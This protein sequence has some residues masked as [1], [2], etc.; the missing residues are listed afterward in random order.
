MKKYR[1]EIDGLR[2]LAIL[3]VILFHAGFKTFSGGFVGVDV[4]FVISGYLITSIILAEN[5]AGTFSLVTF[6]ERRARRILPALFLVMFVSLTFAWFQLLPEDMTKFSAS[7]VAVSIF[8]SNFLFW[9][10]SGYFEHANELSPLLHTW[11]LAVEEQYYVLFPLFLM[12]TWKLGK[13][14]ILTALALMALLG[15]GTAHWGSINKLTFTFYFLPTRGWEILVGAFIAFYYTNHKI[16]KHDYII[17]ELGSLFGFALIIYSIF[18][19]DSQTPFP[20]LYTLAPTIGAALIII[21]STDKTLVG[22][23][24][25]T[26]LML[27]IGL[28]SYSAYLWHQPL[29]AFA[30]QRSLSEPSLYLM[31]TLAVVSFV[32]AYL[33]WQY[34]ERPFRNKHR[35]S[36]KQVFAY[37]I[38]CSIFFIG[39][40]LAGFLNKGFTSRMPIPLRNISETEMPTIDN[41]W[42][43]Y[44]IDTIWKLKVG[45]SGLNCFVGN[46]D[47]KLKAILFG[48][49][50]AGQYEPFWDAVAKRNNISINSVTTNWCHPSFNEQ[51]TGPLSSRAYQQCIFNRKYLQKN[52]SNYS[53][54][55][56]SGMWSDALY[57]NQ[58]EGVLDVINV[59]AV[60]SKLVILMPSPKQFD[61]DI[62]TLYR[63]SLYLNSQFDVTN[64]PHKRDENAINANNFLKD[65]AKKYSNVIYIERDSLFHVNGTPSDISS[66]KKPFSREGFHISIYGS[67]KAAESFIS[68]EQ[69][70]ELV[71][72]ID[73]VR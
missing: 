43:F 69:Y 25:S 36:R 1:P 48:D 29:L 3:P 62:N 22:K 50:F 23:L 6:Y 8:A 31:A 12:H 35:F 68:T 73:E 44:S 27:G 57:R 66:E 21:F 41:G 65:A 49:S 9:R 67:K 42:C 58:I 13:R 20:S 5:Q 14:W 51:F 56:L 11:S 30:R 54:V 39:V 71:K 2:A 10:L 45:D 37:A 60:K 32:L 7:L 19:F 55:I 24:L 16:K 46:K 61:I 47:A 40:G 64:A 53:V 4:F 70:L 72:A 28:V 34:V 18:A 52:I 15:L 38:L 33:S 63:K 26:K 17:E 59:A